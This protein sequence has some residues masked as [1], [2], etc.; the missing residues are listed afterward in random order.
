PVRDI[1]DVHQPDVRLM[2][3]GGRLKGL[4]RRLVRQPL[5]RQLS[6]LVINQREKLVGGVGIARPKRR[7]DAR[8]LIHRRVSISYA[9]M[10]LR[11]ATN[12]DAVQM[13]NRAGSKSVNGTE[14]GRFQTD[15]GEHH[16]PSHLNEGAP[17]FRW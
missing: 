6:Q 13:Q 5:R 9:K 11:A 10:R 7:E 1:V 17:T 2:D 4:T 3:E 12:R 8:D 16:Q 14:T 15:G